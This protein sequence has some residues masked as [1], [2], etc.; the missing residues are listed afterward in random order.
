MAI[1]TCEFDVADTKT[2][3]R[4]SVEVPEGIQEILIKGD[5][6][7]RVETDDAKNRELIMPA[8][9][10][11]GAG[12]PEFD[13]LTPAEKSRYQEAHYRLV[14]TVRNLINYTLIDPSGRHRARGNNRFFETIQLSKTISSL[15][16]IPG[17]LEPGKWE[18][19]V[20]AH[21]VVTGKLVVDIEI[22]MND[23]VTPGIPATGLRL[24]E[25]GDYESFRL[26]SVK[27]QGPGWYG[28]DF[29]LHTHHSDGSHSMAEIMEAQHERGYDFLVL[30]DHNTTL[31]WREEY[32]DHML[33]IP[34][35]EITTFYGHAVVVNRV[36]EIDWFDFDQSTTFDELAAELRTKGSMLSIAHP[37]CI[38]DP[39][40][41]G[42]SWEYPNLNWN[43]ADMIEVWA[44]SWHQRRSENRK[45]LA[46]WEQ[47]LNK[48]HRLV[49]VGGTDIH[50]IEPDPGDCGKTYVYAESYTI[51]GIMEGL[52]KGH[53]FVSQG[54]LIEC[55]G[56]NE[57]GKRYGIGEDLFTNVGE[58]IAFKGRIK[59]L[60]RPCE[61]ELVKKGEVIRQIAVGAGDTEFAWAEVVDG[62]AWYYFRVYDTRRRLMALTNAIFLNCQ[63][64]SM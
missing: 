49:P 25:E 24:Q 31:G 61:L 5:F 59:G 55:Y 54:P 20:E 16:C 19:V 12:D 58:N 28:G 40:C 36:G 47:L 44:G 7:P 22:L 10:R 1:Y 53:V 50:R 15:G 2:V 6:D 32:N 52:R 35:L 62:D 56:E 46:K 45:A 37:Y 38:G 26:P 23:S 17:P 29:H 64:P 3:K 57:D 33:V 41:T 18:L 43:A 8:L 39:V 13:R 30:T 60:D 4:F 42:C 48:G 63:P 27:P 51:E 21:A 14:G 9:R 34:G 11:Y